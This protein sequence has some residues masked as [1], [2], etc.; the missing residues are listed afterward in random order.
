MVRAPL[1]GK[2]PALPLLLTA[3]CCLLGAV[4]YFLVQ[5]AEWREEARGSLVAGEEEAGAYRAM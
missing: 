5:L 1:H 3:T 2:D 4:G